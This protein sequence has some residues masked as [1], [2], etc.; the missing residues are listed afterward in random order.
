LDIRVSP[1]IARRIES[2]RTGIIE[3]RQEVALHETKDGQREEAAQSHPEERRRRIRMAVVDPI[4]MTK[5]N[6]H[7][8]FRPNPSLT[9]TDQAIPPD[10][11][12]VRAPVDQVE[13]FVKYIGRRE[14]DEQPQQRHERRHHKAERKIASCLMLCPRFNKLMN[15]VT[16]RRDRPTPGLT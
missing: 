6:Q 10:F 3:Q 11:V 15:S 7:A 9:N 13:P 16:Q 5:A 4:Y 2:V 8:R 14:D 12:A 1:R